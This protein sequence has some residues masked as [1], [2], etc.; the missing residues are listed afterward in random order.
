MAQASRFKPATPLWSPGNPLG[1]G[2]VWG[3]MLDAPGKSQRN[4]VVPGV[5][6]VTVAA[7][8]MGTGL[9][10]RQLQ[11]NGTNQYA[12][13]PL[14]AALQ[15]VAPCSWAAL[16][17]TN[18]SPGTYKYLLKCS[19]PSQNHVWG[20]GTD[21]ASKPW[22]FARQSGGSYLLV[23]ATSYTWD[24]H[25][26]LYAATYT[27]AGTLTFYVDGIPLATGSGD[28]TLYSYSTAGP[29]V[30]GAVDDSG[31]T[32]SFHWPGNIAA[33]YVWSRALSARDQ[34]RLA[35]DPFAPFRRR[36]RAWIA[37]GVTYEGTL[38]AASQAGS[39]SLSAA[40]SIPGTLGA[41]SQDASTEIQSQA[42]FYGTLGAIAASPTLGWYAGMPMRFGRFLGV[43]L[44]DSSDPLN[45]RCFPGETVD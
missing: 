29:I 11:L 12:T 25:Y 24:T 45:G 6:D 38:D 30:L 18:G 9:F 41:V 3:T 28:G 33:A 35:Q 31:A 17:S 43:T 13:A 42:A 22:A 10:G 32:D 16:A 39:T 1:A 5:S 20:I 40:V 15:V 4:Y 34:L 37:V 7:G 26:H 8:T 23:P 44:I 19:L 14:S 36:P 2:L 21:G 27:S